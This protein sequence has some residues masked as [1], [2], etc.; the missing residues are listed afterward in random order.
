[1]SRY[2]YFKDANGAALD[3]DSNSCTIYDAGGT[4]KA[5]PT[6]T[7]VEDGQYQMDYNLSG[8]E[9]VFGDWRIVV[10]GTITGSP[11]KVG[12]QIF[13]FQVEGLP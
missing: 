12:I 7:K 6:L 10:S 4:Q 9:T 3:P 5:T 2:F 11:D 1:M 8:S 13:H